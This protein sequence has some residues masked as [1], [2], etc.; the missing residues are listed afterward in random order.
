MPSYSHISPIKAG[1]TLRLGRIVVSL[2]VIFAVTTLF[3]TGSLKLIA[4]LGWAE[5]I[6]ILPLTLTTTLSSLGIWLLITLVFGR[7]YCS[8]ACPLGTLQDIISRAPRLRAVFRREHPYHFAPAR[9]YLRLIMLALFFSCVAV[10][11]TRIPALIAPLHLFRQ[12]VVNFVRPVIEWLGGREVLALS[13]YSFVITLLI[14]GLLAIAAWRRG[15]IFCNTLC[16]VGNGLGIFSR[17]SIYHFDIDTDRCTNCRRCE[18]VCKAQCINLDD[19]VVDGSRC[20]VCFNCIASCPDKAIRYTSRHK[21][22]AD[23]LL[24]RI[25]SLTAP[26]ASTSCPS[27]SP[28]KENISSTS[29][30]KPFTPGQTSDL[31]IPHPNETI[32]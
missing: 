1:R 14:F 24:Q 20:V 12:M 31:K 22:L 25:P 8:T 26:T 10:G 4:A 7:I 15:R 5:K 2:G 17:F 29:I 9:N 3:S 27:C 21:R 13:A 28:V 30:A 23:P 32:S 18:H 11:F 16:P 6:Q 19:H